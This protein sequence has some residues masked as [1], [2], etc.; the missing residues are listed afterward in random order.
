MTATHDEVKRLFGDLDDHTIVE[1]L[2]SGA[3]IPEL[4]EVAAH[5]AQETDVMGDMERQLSG[6]A[7]TIYNLLN[8]AEERWEPER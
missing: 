2:A 4:V 1:I 3:T 7:L 5:L 6:R 8:E